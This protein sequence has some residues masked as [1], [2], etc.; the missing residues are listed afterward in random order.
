MEEN[1][2][3]FDN[4][5]KSI[6][7]LKIEFPDFWFDAY[8][9]KNHFFNL[10]FEEATQCVEKLGLSEKFLEEDNCKELWE[11]HCEFCFEKITINN[12]NTCFCTS[13]C[14][15][16]VCNDCFNKLKD[17]YNSILEEISD[18]ENNYLNNI[19]ITEDSNKNNNIKF[20]SSA[21]MFVLVG[22]ILPFTKDKSKGKRTWTNFWSGI[23]CLALAGLFG[24]IVCKILFK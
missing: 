8:K 6:E 2:N 5:L 22:I 16:W 4:Q 20:I 10:V 12:K 9:N 15:F 24:F 17:E 23:F 11:R 19:F 21:W 1:V 7:L 3:K 14:F 13:D 18:K